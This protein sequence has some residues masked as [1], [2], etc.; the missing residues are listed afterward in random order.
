[1]RR[2]HSY[3]RPGV[4]MMK[5]GIC[6]FLSVMLAGALPVMADTEEVFD[7]EPDEEIQ[8]TLSESDGSWEGTDVPEEQDLPLEDDQMDMD[9]FDDIE[10]FLDDNVYEGDIYQEEGMVFEDELDEYVEEPQSEAS[11]VQDEAGELE[12]VT[13]SEQDLTQT[14]D[15]PVETAEDVRSGECGVLE[16]TVFWELDHEGTLHLSGSGEMLDWNSPEEVPW[17]H[18]SELIV[19]LDIQEG[20]SGVG[21]YAFSSCSSLTSAR[22][23]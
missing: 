9:L 11:E 13:E 22:I 2:Y 12:A 1:M 5:R 14:A 8:L 18:C 4:G 19:K 16:G 10:L 7:E 3:K 20:V 6:F 17:Y 21:A 15:E 23:G